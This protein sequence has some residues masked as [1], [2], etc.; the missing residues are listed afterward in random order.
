MIRKIPTM[1]NETAMVPM[2]A[3]PPHPLRRMF[4]KASSTI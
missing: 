4:V 1:M 3:M 2:E